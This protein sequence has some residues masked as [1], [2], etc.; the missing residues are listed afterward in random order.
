MVNKE[1][2][3]YFE[4]LSQSSLETTI[5][6]LLDFFKERKEASDL[7][8]QLILQAGR[9]NEINKEIDN[10][11]VSFSEAK[12]EKSKIRFAILN[13]IHKLSDLPKYEISQLNSYEK[14]FIN[15]LKNLQ[16][17]Q[18][19]IQNEQLDILKQQLQ[20]ISESPNSKT[21]NYI[22]VSGSNNFIGQ[23]LTDTN[24]N[25]QIENRKTEEELYEKLSEVKKIILQNIKN[26][27]I[28]ITKSIYNV[29]HKMTEEN[30][31]IIELIYREIDE[32]PLKEAITLSE[33]IEKKIFLIDEIK[34]DLKALE[35]SI[36]KGDLNTKLK[37]TIPFLPF[38]GVEQEFDI[39]NPIHRIWKK[40]R[41]LI[42]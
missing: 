5:K 16:L 27:N 33:N 14:H 22:N 30:A 38:L 18:N 2:I 3:E 39:T 4:N 6:Q 25:Q 23:N 40:C 26:N 42:L 37:L 1:Y 12:I 35:N 31:R 8:S 11:T 19:Q 32:L 15:D 17:N 10:N 13:I 21:F 41:E 7:Y 24:I 28:E 9:I 34:L 36:K 29:L 20:K